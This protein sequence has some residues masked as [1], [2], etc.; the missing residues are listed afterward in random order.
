MLLQL[1]V[2]QAC[3]STPHVQDQASIRT[4]DHQ[5]IQ[6]IELLRPNTVLF[7]ASVRGGLA[8]R[9][10]FTGAV[11]DVLRAADGATDISAMFDNAARVVL[12][13]ADCKRI[14]QLPELRKTTRK[15]LI[16]PP[17]SGNYYSIYSFA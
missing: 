6:H 12:G 14:H 7:L 13:N 3:Q 8:W 17:T 10:A 2:V 15:L 5:R 11:A 9:G 1:V 4:I 16:L